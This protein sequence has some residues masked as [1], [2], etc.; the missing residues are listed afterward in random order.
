MDNHKIASELL[1][2]A[3]S[4]V[5][6]RKI[7][8]AVYGP[9]KGEWRFLDFQDIGK[10]LAKKIRGKYKKISP[11][12]FE[13]EFDHDRSEYELEVSFLG[14][15]INYTYY[16]IDDDRQQYKSTSGTFRV[17]GNDPEAV[18]KKLR[19]ITTLLS[20]FT[21]YPLTPREMQ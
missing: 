3:E 16:W 19:T 1:K 20:P 14:S 12:S 5:A 15:N 11:K 21:S 18:V 7:R 2:V 6:D 4:L 9:P 8:K 10:Q 13:I 17:K